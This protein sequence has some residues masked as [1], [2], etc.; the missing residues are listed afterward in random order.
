[1]CIVYYTFTY[2]LTAKE[3]DKKLGTAPKTLRKWIKRYEE[4]GRAGLIDNPRSGRPRTIPDEQR[5]LLV[6]IASS[7]LTEFTDH[8]RIKMILKFR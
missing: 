8:L 1:L 3:V 5:K 4:R 2:S 6:R 7:D